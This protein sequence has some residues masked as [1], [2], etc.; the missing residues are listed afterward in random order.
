VTAPAADYDATRSMLFAKTMVDVLNGGMLAAM[1]AIGHRTGL[2]VT[3]AALPP[4]TSA[5]IAEAA[6]LDE[7]Y[8]REWLGAMVT[9]RFVDHDAAAGTYRLP[10]EHVPW[11]T[12]GPGT[13]NLA[14]VAS[15]I[16][17]LS[18]VLDDVIACFHDGGG[19]PYSRY[20]TFQAHMGEQSAG[21]FDASLVDVVLPIVPGLVD[22]L[23][24]GIDAADIG[25]GQGHASNVL[26]A[27]FPASR[28]TGLDLSEQ[29]IAAGRAEAA[30]RGL[31]N[32]TFEV[33]DVA[34]LAGPPRYDFVTAFDAVH[35]Q[36][37]PAAVLRGIADVLRDD[38]TFLMVDI[39]ASSLL[40]ENLDHPLGPY[41]YGTSTLH[42]MTVSLAAGGAGLGTAWGHQVATRMLN[43]AGFTEVEVRNLDTDVAN[44][45][46]L[47]RKG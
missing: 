40:H 35:D 22:R 47:C 16:P 24:A 29:G 17:M 45:Y 11:L 27:A 26:A 34:R 39:R 20:P 46:Y 32:A 30:A 13:T 9:G 4:S 6:G 37:D 31:A 5:E 10:P 23:R 18:S 25:C 1:A 12:S 8:V 28:F 2:F 21:I 41:V 42:C 14:V 3:M 44:S 43:E 36:A 33:T 38:G 7:R 19:V 15:T